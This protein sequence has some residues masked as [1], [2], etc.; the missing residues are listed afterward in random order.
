MERQPRSWPLSFFPSPGSSSSRLMSSRALCESAGGN[1]SRSFL[2][3]AVSLGTI[4][5]IEGN[6]VS[7]GEVSLGFGDSVHG[8]AVGKDVERLNQ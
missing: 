5:S 6:E 7:G 8:V 3:L 2:A 1:P 4:W